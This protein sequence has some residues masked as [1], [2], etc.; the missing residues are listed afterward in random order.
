MSCLYQIHYVPCTKAH[1]IYPYWSFQL[2]FHFQTSCVCLMHLICEIT[3][4]KYI[5]YLI[6][7]FYMSYKVFFICNYFFGF[8]ISSVLFP[9][10]LLP[11]YLWPFLWLVKTISWIF[12]TN[13]KSCLCQTGIQ[14]MQVHRRFSLVLQTTTTMARFCHL[15]YLC[16]RQYRS[17]N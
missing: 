7:K 17:G 1:Q 15:S 2:Q 8:W 12:I 14:R 3:A 6:V 13:S 9:S 11:G 10:D 16:I 5:Y 4:N